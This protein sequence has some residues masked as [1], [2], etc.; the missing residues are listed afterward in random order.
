MPTNAE[1]S[2]RQ[3]EL[4]VNLELLGQ[5]KRSGYSVPSQVAEAEL[6][7]DVALIPGI[8]SIWPILGIARQPDG[9]EPGR[10]I[11]GT[12]S[13]PRFAASLFIQY[14]CPEEL[15]GAN[16]KEAGI[17]RA[18]GVERPLPYFRYELEER[19]LS[20]LRTLSQQV[21]GDAE[22]CY[23]AAAFISLEWL[24]ELQAMRGVVPQSNFLPLAEIEAA[25]GANS[26][27]GRTGPHVWTYGGPAHPGGVLCSEPT[28]LR[29]L[30]EEGL[31]AMLAVLAREG[32]RDF[33]SH[34]F[35]LD[36]A[37]RAW[38]GGADALDLQFQ[39]GVL[40][41]A[42]AYVHAALRIHYSMSSCGVGWYLATVPSEVDRAS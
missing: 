30:D 35:A 36:K 28:R 40:L 42:P 34:T 25:L 15:R 7:Y 39:G 22:V 23:A 8:S 16:A 29:S 6:G 38:E 9:A 11:L 33:E 37:V 31:R 18:L 12:R 13:A 27:A 2:E 4:A 21:G 20:K 1:F 17:R 24:H 14:K 26:G 32:R 10:G 41:Q 5:G 19:Q 3:Y